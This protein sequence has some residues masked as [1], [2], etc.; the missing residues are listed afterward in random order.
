LIRSQSWCAK[1]VLRVDETTIVATLEGMHAEYKQP[2][3][4]LFIDEADLNDAGAAA[5]FHGENRNPRG[6]A[7][8][9]NDRRI[10]GR[11]RLTSI[12]APTTTLATTISLND[13]LDV[14]TLRAAAGHHGRNKEKQTGVRFAEPR[15]AA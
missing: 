12:C 5:S 11:K 1:R 9:I 7:K 8:K 4:I 14:E 2:K 10:Q 3:R 6:R 13:D 15:K